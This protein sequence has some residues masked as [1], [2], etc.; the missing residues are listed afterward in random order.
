[1]CLANGVVSEKSEVMVPRTRVGLGN[2]Y[3]SE[4][5]SKEKSWLLEGLTQCQESKGESTI[6][7]PCDDEEKTTVM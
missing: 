4:H 5:K 3:V 6:R 7:I 2:S 1:M